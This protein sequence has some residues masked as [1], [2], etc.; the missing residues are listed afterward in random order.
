MRTIIS[1]TKSAL[2][3]SLT[4][5]VETSI[6]V[7]GY[8]ISEQDIADKYNIS[9]EDV[10]LL[11]KEGILFELDIKN[12]KIRRTTILNNLYKQGLNFYKEKESTL[13][14]SYTDA[15][16]VN[17]DG[18]LL[19]LLRNKESANFPNVYCLPGGHLETAYLNAPERNVKKEIKEETGLDILN[20]SLI[21][22]KSLKNSKKIYYFH[23]SI[24]NIYEVVLNYREHIQYRWVTL[25]ELRDIP[26]DKFIL[27]LKET[28]LELTT[29]EK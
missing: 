3:N 19:L 18:K 17:P 7:E 5:M 29:T 27:D 11:E 13:D 20:A 21:Y 8:L 15:L 28:L 1:P 23:C 25:S 10:I 12:T 22:I 16:I 24:P 14:S 6:G 2:L 9:V 26:S 4:K